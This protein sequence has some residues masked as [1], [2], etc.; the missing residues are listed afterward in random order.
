LCS[1]TAPATGATYTAIVER[2]LDDYYVKVAQPA[3]VIIG[4]VQPERPGDFDSAAACATCGGDCDPG[5]VW[6]QLSLAGSGALSAAGPL[7]SRC[8]SS[9]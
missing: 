2:A 9:A 7:C 5:G 3:L 8:A 6:W 4:Y 1:F